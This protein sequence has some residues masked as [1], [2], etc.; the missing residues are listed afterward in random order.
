[1]WQKGKICNYRELIAISN[2]E[3][4]EPL[5]DVR[6]YDPT[7]I[8]RYEK[9]D[10]L[11]YTGERIFVRDTVAR[12]LA[13]VNKKLAKYGNFRL[14]VV[15][16][17]RHPDIQKKYF[18]KMRTKLQRLHPSLTDEE[19]DSLTHNFIAVPSVAGHPTGGAI[20]VTI[21]DA[22]GNELDMGTKIA[23]FKNPEKI[24]T[25]AKGLSKEQKKNRRLLHDLL[26]AEGFAPFYG[27]WWHFSYGD[28]EWACFYS[29]K[30]SLYSPV[31]FKVM[32]E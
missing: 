32:Q 19:L 3:N 30:K 6:R 27:E 14:K 24:K 7:I 21:V 5:V 13:K 20:D 2:G 26:I 12:K 18:E 25:F 31:K 8:A 29:K 10:M 1:M 11:P 22:T 4:K 16:G 23:D 9:N 15:Y 28:R 17:Y